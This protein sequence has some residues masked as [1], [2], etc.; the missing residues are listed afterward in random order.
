MSLA[1]RRD[2]AKRLLAEAGYGGGGKPL[3]VDIRFNNSGANRAT[4]VAIA[5]MWKP[6]GVATRILGTDAATH[7]ALLREKAAFR[8]RPHELVRGLSR[9][10]EL[11]VPRAKR[12]SRA[13][14]DKLLERRL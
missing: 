12:Q 13:E 4:A 11:P 10:A 14:H 9:R 7:Y 2:E 3:E 6:L 8:R 1:D 5:D